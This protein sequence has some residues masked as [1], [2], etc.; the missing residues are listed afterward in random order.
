MNETGLADQCVQSEHDVPREDSVLTDTELI[1]LEN[2]KIKVSLN[3]QLPWKMEKRLIEVKAVMKA[4][5][6]VVV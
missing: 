4:M 1:L 2:K 5:E 6:T 3:T